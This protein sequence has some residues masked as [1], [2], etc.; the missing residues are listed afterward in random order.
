MHNG[1]GHKGGTHDPGRG[2]QLLPTHTTAQP[3]VSLPQKNP[4]GTVPERCGQ[5]LRAGSVVDATGPFCFPGVA[6]LRLATS[7]VSRVAPRGLCAA[8][9]DYRR[10]AR[11]FSTRTDDGVRRRSPAQ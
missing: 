1:Q 7:S 11:L 4:W 6:S 5:L 8:R 10:R 2:R 9:V 3:R